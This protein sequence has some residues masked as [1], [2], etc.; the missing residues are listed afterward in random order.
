MMWWPRFPRARWRASE[1]NSS[2]EFIECSTVDALLGQEEF[3]ALAFDSLKRFRCIDIGER[4]VVA[5]FHLADKTGIAAHHRAGAGIAIQRLQF[6]KELPP[7]QDR[8]AAFAPVPWPRRWRGL[9]FASKA[10]T[11]FSINEAFMVGHVAEQHHR[12]CAFRGCTAP[13]PARKEVL[14]PRAK[15]SFWDEGDWCFANGLAHRG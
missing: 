1:N 4:R 14:R 13:I 2:D 15:S 6:R 11:T 7:P 5:C 12:A 3:G 9:R 10:F 8:M